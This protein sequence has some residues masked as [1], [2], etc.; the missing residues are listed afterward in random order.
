LLLGA[1]GLIVYLQGYGGSFKGFFDEFQ[2]RHDG[3]GTALDL[4]KMVTQTFPAFRDEVDYEGTKGD[5]F[6][7]LL[8]PQVSLI[9]LIVS[10]PMETR[11]DSCRRDM[12]SVLS[13][14][15]Q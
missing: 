1:R 12:G 4:V 8:F 14:R 3:Q 2:R 13:P 10:V 7:L 5:L 15:L 6:I 11:P 9:I